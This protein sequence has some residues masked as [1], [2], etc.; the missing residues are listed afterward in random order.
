MKVYIAADHRGYHLK[1]K[2]FQWLVDGGY[3]VE[4][5]GAYELNPKDDYP[6]FA[7]KVG[8]VVSRDNKARGI[9]LCGGGTGINVVANK[10]DRVRASIGINTK[11][12][13][14][15]RNDDDIN[16]LVIAADF[17]KEN[18]A[19]EMVKIF[20]ETKYAGEPRHKRRLE[21]ITRIEANN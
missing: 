9:L 18:Q 12:V 7:E 16:I 13:M 5:Y 3:K 19:K 8:S 21:E 14:A 10:F 4:D 15:G 17:T 1:E 20:L 2:I 11:Q 6:L